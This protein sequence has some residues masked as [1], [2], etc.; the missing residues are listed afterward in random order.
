MALIEGIR[1]QNYR[2]LKDI[3]LGRLWNKRENSPLTP[4]VT[5]IGKNGVGKSTLFDAFGF[6]ADCLRFGVEEAFDLKQRGGFDR[7]VSSGSSGS[8]RFEVYYRESPNERPITY[9]LLISLD[10]SGRPYV[11]EE[12]LRQRCKGQKESG[13]PYSFLILHSGIGEAWAGE[14]SYEGEDANRISVELT[15][16]RKLGIATLGTLKEHPR[17]AKFRD[18]LEYVHVDGN[19]HWFLMGLDLLKDK[20]PASSK[21]IG[22]LF[23]EMLNFYMP[24]YET[25][26]IRSIVTFLYQ[27]DKEQQIEADQICEIYGRRGYDKILRDIYEQNHNFST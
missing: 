14:E 2:V 5:V 15:D 8:I 10:R 23:L 11:E 17:I 24:V 21:Y 9:E 13:R 19:E 20:D 16:P 27:Q 22:K 6:L 12:R 7:L 18:F 25:E 1:I 3:T 4:L 26:N